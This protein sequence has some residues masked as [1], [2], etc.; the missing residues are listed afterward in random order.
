MLKIS[1]FYFPQI[2]QLPNIGFVIVLMIS[3]ELLLAQ[4]YVC[5]GVGC[6]K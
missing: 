4:I 5:H 1:Y 2:S 3:L 6:S